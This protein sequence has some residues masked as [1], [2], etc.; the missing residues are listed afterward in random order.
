[1][2]AVFSAEVAIVNKLI[3][4]CGNNENYLIF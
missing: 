3:Q 4:Q 1:L 2:K